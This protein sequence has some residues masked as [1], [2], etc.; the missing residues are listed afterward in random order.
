[1][2]ALYNQIEVLP[3]NLKQ[4]VI[5]FVEFL[6]KK[7]KVEEA[8]VF[9]QELKDELDERKNFMREHPETNTTMAALKHKLLTKYNKQDV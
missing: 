6:V 4:E 1:M 5:D 2:Q 8:L 9:N 3:E 7:Y